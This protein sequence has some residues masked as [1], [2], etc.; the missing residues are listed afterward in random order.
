MSATN[1][2][3]L[4]T[5]LYCEDQVNPLGIDSPY[6]RLSWKFAPS[7]RNQ[8]AFQV[9][10]ASRS[11]LLTGKPS[12]DLWDSGRIESDSTIR[13]HYAGETLSS[14]QRAWWI[15]RIWDDA[16]NITAA[17]KSCFWEMGLLNSADWKA[18]WISGLSP[19]ALRIPAAHLRKSFA[20][21]EKPI[22][23]AR[24]YATAQGIYVGFLNGQRVGQDHFRPGWTEYKKRIQYQTYDVTSLVTPGDNAIGFILG[25][26][27]F[28]G[29][30][31]WKDE[32]NH[33]GHTPRLLAQLQIDYQDG[34]TQ[35]I[36]TDDSWRCSPGP[37]LSSDFLM[38]EIYDARHE[39]PGWSRADF[40][41]QSWRPVK[42]GPAPEVAIVSQ[43]GPS[44][45][46]LIELPPKSFKPGPGGTFVFDF[47]Q[48]IVGWARLRVGGRA[49]TTV[50]LRFAEALNPDGTIYTENLAARGPSINTPSAATPMKSSSPRS[51][52][53]AS[54]LLKSA[55]SPVN[56]ISTPSPASLSALTFPR[57][58]ASNAPIPSSISF[59]A[60]S[61]GAS[62]EIFWKSPPIAP[63][64]TS[65]SAG[66]PMPRSSFPP[67][68]STWTAARSSQ[69]GCRISSTP[70]LRKGG[71]RM[72]PP[73]DRPQ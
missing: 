13:V 72:F 40:N 25:D 47:G 16:G 30:L 33:Y 14:A 55:A 31:G 39:F 23:Q 67:Q 64:A 62:A 66:W 20:L 22:R 8:S 2:R 38:G 34:S 63:S 61:S 21:E 29:E 49:G 68:H 54:A 11:G 17:A 15:V 6:P 51:P 41:D 70:N 18:T 57:P 59:K 60:T 5:T 56:P 52:S 71:S 26:G 69:N 19:T 1:D 44:V 37:I 7:R 53:T 42:P 3:L 73:N 45:R 50:I 43:I 36:V 58:A 12:P 35:T 28:C 32:R 27:W 9:L 24:L 48:N 4:I 10:V 46:K 65:A